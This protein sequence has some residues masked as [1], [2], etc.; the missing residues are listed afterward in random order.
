MNERKILDQHPPW[1]EWLKENLKRGCEHLELKKI[2]IDNGFDPHS[3]EAATRSLTSSPALK[4]TAVN[5]A[6]VYHAKPVTDTQ[7]GLS[8][9][10]QSEGESLFL[11]DPKN[12]ALVSQVLTPRMQLYLIADF[13]T[14]AECQDLMDLGQ[15]HLRASTVSY[16]NE[17]EVNG[18]NPAIEQLADQSYVD[19]S[20]RTSQTCDLALLNHPKVMEMDQRIAQTLGVS[21][22]LAE[23]T[24]LQRYRVGEQ[25]KAHTD[26]FLP[27]S[28]EFER[29]ASVRG[30]RTWTFMVYL[31]EVKA[32][33]GTRFLNVQKTI[34]PKQ[35]MAVVWHNLLPSQ[36]VNPETL[37]AG[38]P[39][40]EGEKYVITKWFRQR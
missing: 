18:S 29:Y 5:S 28:V 7:S 39:V 19:L 14:P 15:A 3:V 12:P 34:Q 40:I 25:F 27:H 6:Q 8:L 24:Q 32:G 1:L 26:Y 35:G 31:N 16:P 30:N 10:W 33:G 17:E 36:E 37:H 2:L 11:Q 22:A 38:L 21:L 23:G 20:F 9:E 13:M 4:P